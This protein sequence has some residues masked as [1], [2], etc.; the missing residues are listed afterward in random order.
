MLATRVI[1]ADTE[2]DLYTIPPKKIN[3]APWSAYFMSSGPNIDSK[4]G[5]RVTLHK[6]ECSEKMIIDVLEFYRAD[7]RRVIAQYQ[8][9]YGELEKK[10]PEIVKHPHKRMFQNIN[11]IGP[12]TF[13]LVTLYDV[14]EF[15]WVKGATFKIRV[16]TDE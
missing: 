13:E 16:R 9:Y 4:T 8:I 2:F 5:L 11:W 14:I 6:V 15:K 1:A 12:K 3:A 7:I 10:F